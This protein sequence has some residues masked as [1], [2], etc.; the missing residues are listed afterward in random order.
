MSYGKMRVMAKRK[1]AKRFTAVEAVKRMARA[2]IGEPP[3]SRV[4]PHRKKNA[5]KH[6]P[7]LGKLLDET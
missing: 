5:E 2:H 7:T 6:K 1:K 3:A 4:V